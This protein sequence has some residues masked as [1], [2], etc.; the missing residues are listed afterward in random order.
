MATIKQVADFAQVSVATVSR[1]INKNGYVSPDLEERV[2][3]AMDTLHYQPN[4]VARSLRTQRSMT[5]GLLIP[6]LDH[7]F[8]STLAFAIERS[9]FGDD[10]RT[11]ICSAEENPEKENAYVEMFMA[12]RVDGVICVPTGHSAPNVARLI[13]REIPLVLVD[14]DLPQITAS[15]VRTDNDMGGYTGIKHLLDLGHRRIG[16]IGTPA[17][18]EPMIKRMEGVLRG[19]QEYDIDYQPELLVTGTLQQFEMGFNTAIEM[20]RTAER[21]TAIFALTDVIA[22]GGLHA[23][24]KLG[25]SV[26]G[27]ISVMGFDNIPLAAYSIPALT[28]VAQPIYAMGETVARLLLGHLADETQPA[29]TII[30]QN[31]LIVR[32]STDRPK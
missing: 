3:Q 17:Y 15:R 14:R 19:L 1:V 9:L 23:A 29:E 26:P 12:Q 28:T 32:Q 18:S 30:M 6:Q 22:I 11:L 20:L 10:Y 16:V 21:P 24:A 2:R 13:E 8:F 4:S 7:P 27:D 31:E 25:L 5:V